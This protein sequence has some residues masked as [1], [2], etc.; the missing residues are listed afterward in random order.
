MKADISPSTHIAISVL[1]NAF[2]ATKSLPT[3]SF[4]SALVILLDLQFRIAHIIERYPHP[5]GI[6]A[7]MFG[8]VSLSPNGDRFVGWGSA[9]GMSQFNPSGH[10]VYDAEFGNDNA[11]IGSYRAF[12]APWVGRPNTKPDVYAYAWGCKWRSVVYV[13][14][15][16]AT[17]VRS[18]RVFGA[19]KPEDRFILVAEVDKGGFETM[20]EADRYVEYAFVEALDRDGVALGSSE[21]ERMYRPPLVE[22]RGCSEWRCPATLNLPRDEGSCGDDEGTDMAGG[23]EQVVL[24]WS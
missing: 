15:N 1:D 6:T 22:G 17:E 23:D 4:S 13:S 24:G 20:V 3:A 9:R 18:Y 7:A 10:L 12:K 16:G 11:L 21:M 19:M 8:S 2:G 5:R 14:W